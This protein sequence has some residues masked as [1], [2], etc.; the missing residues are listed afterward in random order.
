MQL[1]RANKSNKGFRFQQN[2]YTPGVDGPELGGDTGR[3]EVP[4]YFPTVQ[5]ALGKKGTDH[6]KGNTIGT[7]VDGK[8]VY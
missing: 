2:N 3:P 5:Q 7:V 1:L 8:K 4:G 6:Q